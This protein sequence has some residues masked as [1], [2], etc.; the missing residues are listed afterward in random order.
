MNTQVAMFD[1][2][3]VGSVVSFIVV[4]TS[5]TYLITV[6]VEVVD[7][8][9]QIHTTV[10]MTPLDE[11]SSRRRDLYLTTQTL[12]T[13]N[14]HA[15]GGIRTHIPASARPQTKALDRAATEIGHGVVH[16]WRKFSFVVIT[17]HVAVPAC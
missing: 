11:G 1:E 4:L 16:T 5:S 7:F 8:H 2:T 9:T 3:F 10:G 6:G 12:Y 13:T 14:I 15:L 17:S